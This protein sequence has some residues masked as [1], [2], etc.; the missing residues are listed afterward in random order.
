MKICTKCKQEK[1]LE[2]FH[3]EK[4]GKYGVA[5]ICKFCKKEL[6]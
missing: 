1:E 2:N 6:N 3:K 5:S 4:Y